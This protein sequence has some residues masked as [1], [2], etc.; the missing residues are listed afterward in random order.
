M[1]IAKLLLACTVLI[2]VFSSCQNNGKKYDYNGKQNIYYKGDGLDDAAAKKLA[3][4]LSDIKYFGGDKELSVQM[5]KDKA[6][7]DTVN[8][9][10]VVDQS[11]ITSEIESAFVQIGGMI[12]TKVYNGGPVNLNFIDDHFKLVKKLGY[13][14]PVVEEATRPVEDNQTTQPSAPPPTGN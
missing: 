2:T 3:N 11:K 1:K 13:A 12:S 4:F 5:T 14:Q 10:F 6:T 8:I 9:N 7:G